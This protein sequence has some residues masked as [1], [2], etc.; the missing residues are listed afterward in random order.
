M[1][2][3]DFLKA[4]VIQLCELCEVVNVG[5]D[6]TQ[7]LFQ[8]AKLGFCRLVETLGIGGST[9]L[10]NNLVHFPFTALDSLNNFSRLDPLEGKDL[11]QLPFELGNKSLFVVFAPGLMLRV[12]DLGGR[13][14]FKR[15]LE[16][17]LEAI[18][19]DIVV[20][21]ILDQRGSELLAD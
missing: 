12:R 13:R 2:L 18:V 21:P 5:Y 19:G 16:G 3:E 6:I 4:S 11:L 20:D 8:Q 9:Q 17:S 7:I 15:R 14:S 1:L 10:S